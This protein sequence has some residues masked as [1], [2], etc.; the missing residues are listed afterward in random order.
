MLNIDEKNIYRMQ[1]TYPIGTYQ[2]R[3]QTPYFSAYKTTP[4][5]PHLCRVTWHKPNIVTWRNWSA[6]TFAATTHRRVIY[7]KAALEYKY[8]DLKHFEQSPGNLLAGSGEYSP[9]STTT[10]QIMLFDLSLFIFSNAFVS[11]A[12]SGYPVCNMLLKR[13]RVHCLREIAI[14]Y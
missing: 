5:Y 8:F 11:F 14:N 3:F 4:P 7:L 13:S 1:K 6:P 10:W 9:I 12:Y 2:H